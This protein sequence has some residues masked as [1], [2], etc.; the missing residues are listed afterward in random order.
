MW[1]GNTKNHY[2]SEIPPTT[3]SS[4]LTEAWFTLQKQQLAWSWAHTTA[5]G[6]SLSIQY[7]ITYRPY[8]SYPAGNT[9]AS[10]SP[11]WTITSTFHINTE[12]IHQHKYII[13]CITDKH[14]AC[15]SFHKATSAYQVYLWLTYSKQE[16]T[17]SH[18]GWHVN[19]NQKKAK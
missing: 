10:I 13:E 4:S 12:R 19:T 17:C 18:R 5:N 15:G 3:Y 14:K 9:S 11:W 8:P 2:I 7:N 16:T 1:A 6:E